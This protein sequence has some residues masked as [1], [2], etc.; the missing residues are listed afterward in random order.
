MLP[1]DIEKRL[2]EHIGEKKLPRKNKGGGKII[3]NKQDYLQMR[4]GHRKGKALN[5]TT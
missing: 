1:E 5:S 3:N 4:E 2:S